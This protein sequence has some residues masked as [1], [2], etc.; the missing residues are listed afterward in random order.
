MQ[1][2]AKE[3]ETLLSAVAFSAS[4]DVC[5]TITPD[6]KTRLVNLI[7][8]LTLNQVKA[9]KE[10]YVLDQTTLGY[11]D[12]EITKKLISDAKIRVETRK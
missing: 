3:L 2:N 9:G 6:T 12:E 10:L 7:D 8:R 11:E 1:F 5:W 4:A